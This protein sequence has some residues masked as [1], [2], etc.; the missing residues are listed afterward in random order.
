[1]T[2]DYL[3]DADDPETW[4]GEQGDE[5]HVDEEILNEHGLW[6]C[7]HEV[8]GEVDGE[9]LCLFHLPVDKK[10]DERVV[11]AF[12]EV[13]EGADST[14]SKKQGQFLG[15]RFGKFELSENT[16]VMQDCLINLS[17]AVFDE[18]KAE[19]TEFGGDL[20]CRGIRVNRQVNFKQAVFRG[21]A[22]FWDVEFGSFADFE[23]VEFK[24]ALSF[25]NADFGLLTDF[26][27]VTFEEVSDFS[28]SEF[29]G[30]VN[31]LYAN[32]NDIVL[33]ESVKFGGDATFD[34]VE[35]SDGVSFEDTIFEQNAEFWRS[36]FFGRSDFENVNFNGEMHFEQSEF[37][38]YANFVGLTLDGC[39]FDHANLTDVEF[40]NTSLCEANLESA[41]L[42][43]AT[44]LG[45]DL[46]GAKLNGAVLGDV[47][48]NADTQFLGHPKG[49]SNSSPYTFSAI[50]SKP[51][52][53]YDPS[54]NGDSDEVDADK[55]KTVYRALE[56]LAG[57]AARPRLQSQCFVR[58]QDLQK[59][60]YWQDAKDAELCQ[61][62]LIAG[63]RYSRAK[64]AQVTLL[65]G[66]S[67]WRIIGGSVGF[68][69]VEIL[70]FRHIYRSDS[71]SLISANYRNRA[72]RAITAI[73]TPPT[74]C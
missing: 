29:E 68:G 74:A 61:E 63:G 46:R 26:S 60:G 70:L 10:D 51:C 69:S 15:G 50:R 62:R 42:S 21:N 2:C 9:H 6:G 44:L 4:D 36:E 49:D 56:E 17:H 1:M 28:G 39:E 52:C 3:L 64:V 58:R 71:Y 40:T 31:F 35:F 47:R 12:L 66:E 13:V 27:Y 37:Y 55:A 33:F 25:E 8:A 54:Y 48:I 32:F 19:Q 20:V 65:Y 18:I 43:R 45:T 14:D 11:E 30:D 16:T 72:T 59:D 34:S 41:M 22:V 23:F 73:T 5:C 7:P 38:E 67:P 57:K 24:E 53:V